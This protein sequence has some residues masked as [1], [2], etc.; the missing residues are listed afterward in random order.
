M[1][2]YPLWTTA[3]SWRLGSGTERSTNGCVHEIHD[4]KRRDDVESGGIGDTRQQRQQG[5]RLRSGGPVIDA[6]GEHM[7]DWR[8]SHPRPSLAPTRPD[9]A[10]RPAKRVNPIAAITRFVAQLRW[11]SCRWASVMLSGTAECSCT[12]GH[13]WEITVAPRRLSVVGRQVRET[14]FAR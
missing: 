7:G 8:P 10:L 2:K 4:L 6:I 12:I 11:N 13:A 9:R 1:T 5:A 14:R 3:M